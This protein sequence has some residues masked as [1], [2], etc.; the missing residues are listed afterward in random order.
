VKRARSRRRCEIRRDRPAAEPGTY[1]A[2][3]AGYNTLG[4]LIEVL[5]GQS[6]EAFLKARIYDPLG[7][8]DSLNHEDPAKLQRMTTVYR[9]Q[10][11][12]DGTVAFTQGFTPGDAPDFPVIRASGGLISTAADYARFLEIPP[13][14]RVNGRR[15]LKEATGAPPLSR[16]EGERI[17]AWLRLEHQAERHRAHGFGRHDG[18]DRSGER[19]RRHGA[20]AKPWGQQPDDGVQDAD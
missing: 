20:H 17:L 15:F 11:R 3:N 14:R 10:R 16:G 5:S 18:V 8:V 13:R 4:A 2:N 6:L 19:D 7:M 1:P 9:G 12:A